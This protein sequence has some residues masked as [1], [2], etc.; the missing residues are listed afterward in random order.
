LRD[1]ERIE[2][3]W[4]VVFPSQRGKLRDRSNTNADLRDAL[5]PLGFEWITSHTFRKTAATLLNH[6]GLTVREVADQLGHSRVSITQDVYFGRGAGSQRA[7]EILGAI[8][9]SK[10]D[11][12]SILPVS[13]DW[14]GQGWRRPIDAYLRRHADRVHS[15]G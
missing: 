13:A 7:A 2:N 8:D 14:R 15:C 1:R 10:A 6:G 11:P 9:G 12:F 5:N 3:E 4:D